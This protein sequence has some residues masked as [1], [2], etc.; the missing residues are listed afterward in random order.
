[1]ENLL[2]TTRITTTQKRTALSFSC[3]NILDGQASII[4]KQK[5]ASVV[6]NALMS[7]ILTLA[8]VIVNYS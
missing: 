6:F 8:F 1:M 2:E 3:K 7:Y 4:H 5:A